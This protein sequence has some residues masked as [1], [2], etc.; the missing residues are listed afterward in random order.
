MLLGSI[1][2]SCAVKKWSPHFGS[3]VKICT[4]YAHGT[5]SSQLLEWISM[6]TG[7][8]RMYAWVDDSMMNRHPIIYICSI[9]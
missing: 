8:V 3:F 4:W 1:A 5:M 6:C 7:V 2:P 9:R